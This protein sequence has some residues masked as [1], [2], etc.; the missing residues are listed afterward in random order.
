MTG[1]I[2]P[3]RVGP[4]PFPM[5]DPKTRATNF[6]EVQ[7]PYNRDEVMLEADRCVRCANPVCIEVCPVQMD[8]RGMCDAVANAD[9]KTAFLRIT[10][11][12][13]MLGVTARCCPQLQGL[14]EEACVM[15]YEGHPISIGMIQRFVADWERN[16]S[17]QLVGTAGETTGKRV[18]IVGAGPAGLAAAELL[19][20]YGHSVTIYEELETPGG[21]ARYGI[22]DYHLPK[23]VLLYEINRIKRL[24]VEIETGIKIGR[25]ISLNQLFSEQ[26][27]AILVTTGSKD[28]RR[29]ELP[30]ADL[31]GVFDG[32][33]FLEAVYVNGVENYIEN[34]SFA[35]GT[36]I[37]VVGGGD[38]ALDAARTALR[39]TRGNVTV[40]YR[41]TE[42]EMP[43]DP[44]VI[45]QARDEGV[46]FGFLLNPKSFKG[47]GDKITSATLCE[48]RLGEPDVTGRKHPVPIPGKEVQMECD[49]V[50]LTVGRGPNSFLQKQV[51]MKTGKKDYIS[52]DNHYRT[53]ITGV[54]AAGDVITGESLVVRAMGDGRQAAQRV[55]E[56][57]LDLEEK[58]VSLF[59]QYFTQRTTE[60]Y[61]NTMIAGKVVSSQP[62]P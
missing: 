46:N 47:N 11:T 60:R 5:A 44:I 51:G 21:T 39:L 19:R 34:P 6:S 31:K 59:E 10:E 61:Y 33:E 25:D 38:S 9:F 52:V 55:H 26:A 18:A 53:S 27:D 43:A 22:P 54:Y 24:G 48:M 36:R 7:Q 14:C 2:N 20:R 8:V 28:V 45:D 37:L 30:G 58:H 50:L 16:E 13:A 56:Y 4:F 41:R 57:L 3:T 32:Y 12:N 40:I 35:L 1:K 42:S 49:S 23:D 15:R 29:L 17:R 62:P